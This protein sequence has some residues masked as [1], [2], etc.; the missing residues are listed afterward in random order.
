MKERKRTKHGRSLDW[1]EGKSRVFRIISRFQ[2]AEDLYECHA[3]S[4]YHAPFF[5]MEMYCLCFV[6]ML[7]SSSDSISK[8]IEELSQQV[9]TTRLKFSSALL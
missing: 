5:G 6:D 7:R 2:R 8:N 3:C 4:E 1:L 9:R